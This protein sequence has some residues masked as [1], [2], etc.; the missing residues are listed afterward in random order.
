[1]TAEVKAIT[2]RVGRDGFA[3]VPRVVGEERIAALLSALRAISE[4]VGARRKG[5]VY[6]IRNLLEVVPSLREVA[7]SAPVRS[8]VEP[9]LGAECF[10]VRAIFFDKTP[11]ANWKVAWHQDLSIAV[12]RRVEAEGFGAWTEKAGVTH[13]QPPADVL[14]DMLALRLH[15]DAS[16]ETNGSLKV[17]PGSHLS[18]RLGAVEIQRWREGV[19]PVE[20]HVPRGGALLMKPLLLHASSASREPRH[21]RVVHLEFAARELPSGLEWFGASARAAS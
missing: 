2:R 10:V 5:S 21:R 18:G 15:L 7:E 14:R 19:E 12:R 16:D 6:A 20:C 13:V 3:I 1:M 11:E 4:G 17:I 8:L 9:L